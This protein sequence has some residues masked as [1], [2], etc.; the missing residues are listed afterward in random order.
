MKN[1]TTFIDPAV[2]NIVGFPD[3]KVSDKSDF[4]K[5]VSVWQR[6]MDPMP[7]Y[8]YKDYSLMKS[9]HQEY[10]SL[11]TDTVNLKEKV[12]INISPYEFSEYT[13]KST[14][15]FIGR[16]MRYHP[17]LSDFQEAL[18]DLRSF[19][20]YLLNLVR[21]QATQDSD[22]RK[23]KMRLCSNE[24]LEHM[25]S[26]ITAG[27]NYKAVRNLMTGNGSGDKLEWKSIKV[28]GC[29]LQEFVK[30]YNLLHLHEPI[31]QVTLANRIALNSTIKGFDIPSSEMQ[32]KILSPAQITEKTRM[33]V[34]SAVKKLLD[35]FQ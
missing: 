24:F 30:E 5:Y 12:R 2:G 20:R 4:K 7:I 31:R 10:L 17:N 18:T 35:N 32:R 19:E 11:Y 13:L 28:A 16:L 8:P 25:G 27:K 34:R 21:K 9:I 33:R 26:L 14:R 6:L 22:M 29:F 1:F 23:M 3:G 15:D